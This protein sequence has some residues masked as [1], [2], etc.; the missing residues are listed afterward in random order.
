ML[1]WIDNMCHLRMTVHHGPG[2][3]AVLL[4]VTYYMVDH[5]LNAGQFPSH[6]GRSG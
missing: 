4:R 1:G 3:H 2:T 5:P 6:L